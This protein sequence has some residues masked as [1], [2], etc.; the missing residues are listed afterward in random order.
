MTND[1]LALIPSNLSF[2]LLAK[3]KLEVNGTKR[4][5]EDGGVGKEWEI[6]RGEGE[7]QWRDG[8]ADEL[9]VEMPL[10]KKR[11]NP[12]EPPLLPRPSSSHISF[13][14]SSSSLDTKSLNLSSPENCAGLSHFPSVLELNSPTRLIFELPSTRLR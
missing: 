9:V 13:S 8:D 12:E 11:E 1:Y 6:E 5:G 10:E 2:L 14:P 7:G 3:S 4:G